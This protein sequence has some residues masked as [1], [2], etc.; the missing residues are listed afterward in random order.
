M[1]GPDDEYSYSADLQ[2]HLGLAQHR[3]FDGKA[4]RRSDVTQPEHGEFASDDDDHHP[5][6]DQVHVYQRYE[7]GG[8][9]QLVGNWVEQDA[10]GGDL[11]AAAGE[12]AIGPI[13]GG[14]EQENGYAENLEVHGNAP[15]FNIGAAGQQDNNEE[16]NKEN[17]QQRQCI[18]KIHQA[19]TRKTRA[20]PS[21]MGRASL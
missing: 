1:P 6:G 17:P 13:G 19:L 7:S 10:Q 5:G 15:E 16:R 21:V 3:G 20:L 8:D 9:E 2:D 12:V 4:F 18:W 14:S 11:Q